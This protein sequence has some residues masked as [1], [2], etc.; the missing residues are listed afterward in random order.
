VIRYETAKPVPEPA[1]LDQPHLDGPRANVYA[2]AKK[3]R[4]SDKEAE[5]IFLKLGATA[6]Q[7]EMLAEA[8]PPAPDFK[9]TTDKSR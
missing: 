6:T 8:K 2:F 3:Y 7:Q 9:I 1:H 5:R 4:L